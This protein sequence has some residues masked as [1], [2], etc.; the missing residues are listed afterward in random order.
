MQFSGQQGGY[1]SAGSQNEVPDRSKWAQ[2][3]LFRG[4]RLLDMV[5]K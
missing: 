5:Q 2:I 1:W 3:G 4:V